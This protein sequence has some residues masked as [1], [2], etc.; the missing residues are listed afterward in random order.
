MKDESLV[1]YQDKDKQIEILLKEKTIW[2]DA[3]KIALLFDVQRPAVVKHISNI[4]KTGELNKNLTCSKMEQVAA[5][6]KKRK[7]NLYNLDVIIAVG[8]RVN[9]KK[10]TQFRIWA[11]NVLKKYLINGYVINQKKIT[12]KKLEELE[13]T[14][15][16]IKENVSKKELSSN[17]AKGLLEIIEAHTRT[18]SLFYFYDEG[19]LSA[20][21]TEKQ[22]EKLT[23]EEAKKAIK[24]FKEILLNE[25]LATDIFGREREKGVFKGIIECVFQIFDGKELYKS[26]EEKAANLFYLIIKDHPFIDGNKRIATLLFLMFLNRNLSFEEILEKFNDNTLV[27][28]ALLVAISPHQ[29]KEIMVNLITNFIHYRGKNVSQT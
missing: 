25:N 26:F 28:L 18:W 14:I 13:N 17:E 22:K 19:K 11:T 15:K 3:H 2:L 20:I 5:D 4:Y 6:G 7:M 10:A 9:S 12:Q 8:Y 21:K 24:R 29:Q 23:Y 16:F 27:S 1:I